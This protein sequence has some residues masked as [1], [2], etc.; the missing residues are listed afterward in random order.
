M[1]ENVES[2]VFEC[3]DSPH[4][5]HIPAYNSMISV[6]DS[7]QL[8]NGLINISEM[9]LERIPVSEM[10]WN[11]SIYLWTWE[12]KENFSLLIAKEISLS[13]VNLAMPNSSGQSS[14][15]FITLDYHY[16][17]MPSFTYKLYS[18]SELA[19]YWSLDY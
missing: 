3:N 18:N 4:L 15:M 2:S 7:L 6:K 10:Y 8:S 14:I 5:R 9:E 1:E 17:N 12:N 11:A 16:K 19:L 13:V